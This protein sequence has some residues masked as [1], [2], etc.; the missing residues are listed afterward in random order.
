MEVYRPTEVA[1]IL[2]LL[3][4][5]PRANFLTIPSVSHSHSGLYTCTAANKAGTVSYSTTLNVNG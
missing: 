5:G 1:E 3:R 2:S 4:A